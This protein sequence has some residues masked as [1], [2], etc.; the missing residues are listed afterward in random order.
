MLIAT[1]QETKAVEVLRQGIDL[2]PY[3]P[4]L[5]QLLG[6]TY[7][8]LKNPSEACKVA[9]K[10]NQLFPQDDSL[11]GFLRQCDPAKAN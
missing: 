1:H 10:A 6:R 11:R 9:S 4:E 8:S 5:Y 3:D 2:V 7:A